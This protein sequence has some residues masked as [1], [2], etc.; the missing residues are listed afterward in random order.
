MADKTTCSHDNVFECV[1]TMGYEFQRPQLLQQAMVH[2]SYAIEHGKT[3]SDNEV[4]EFL[5]DSVLNL[6]ISHML[7]HYYGR[8]HNEGDLTRMRAALVNEQQLAEM[9]K[10]VGLDRYILLGRGELKSG[11][12]QKNSILGD[13]FE[14]VI[15]AIYLDGGYEA[16]LGVI[17]RCFLDLIQKAESLMCE[18]DYKTMLQEETQRLFKVTPVYKLDVS[19][20]PDHEK[21]FWVSL[22]LNDVLLSQ[23]SGKSKKEAEQNAAREALQSALPLYLKGA[24]NNSISM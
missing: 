23:G 4:L 15:G 18:Q 12:L 22:Y 19:S 14:A 3:V 20:G 13:V 10:R 2:R 9:T 6:G 5:G 11:G 8:T 24:S 16:A 1:K 17:G 7:F 21:T